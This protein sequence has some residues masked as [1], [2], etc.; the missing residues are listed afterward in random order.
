MGPGHELHVGGTLAVA[1]ADQRDA[2]VRN[3]QRHR[4]TAQV[5]DGLLEYAL[6]VVRAVSRG[7]MV[8][9][10]VSQQQLE[11]FVERGN[12]AIELV[13]GDARHQVAPQAFERRA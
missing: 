1:R 8:G 12:R 5:L 10:T 7:G 9:C 11:V 6:Q 3:Y 2:F 13:D 4:C